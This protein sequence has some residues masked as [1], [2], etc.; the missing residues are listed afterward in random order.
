MRVVL[1]SVLL[2]ALAAGAE[3]ITDASKIKPGTRAFTYLFT[4]DQTAEMQR[5]GLVWDRELGLQQG[6]K[7]QYRMQARGITLASPIELPENKPHP[8]RGSWILRFTFERCG[9]TKIYNALFTAKGGDKPEAKPYFP[10]ITNASPQL[11]RD[12]M[13]GAVVAAAAKLAKQGAK[14]CK[15]LQVF[16]MRVVN[17]SKQGGPWQEGWTFQGCGARAEV[18]VVFTPD[19]KGGAYYSAA[20]N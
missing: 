4:R 16:D 15:V 3:T 18:K 5:V 6:C 11:V 9:E 8:V 14:D 20:E 1:F 7:E 12:A 2:W 17:P 13:H 10:G 19:G